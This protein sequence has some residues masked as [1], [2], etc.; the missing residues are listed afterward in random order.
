LQRGS[1]RGWAR[2]S[3]PADL[4]PALAD[5]AQLESAFANLAINARDAMPQGGRRAIETANKQLDLDDTA[6]NIDAAPGDYVMLAVSD[7]GTGIAPSIL[8]KVFEPFFT[9]RNRGRGPASASAWSTASPSNPA[10]T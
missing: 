9:P 7:N 1:R 5:P 6:R 10:D 4:W 3:D 8:D 2:L